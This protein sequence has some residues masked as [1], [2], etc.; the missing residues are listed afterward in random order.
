MCV[1]QYS[2]TDSELLKV[3]RRAA[4]HVHSLHYTFYYSISRLLI[5]FLLTSVKL[6]VK[7]LVNLLG[8][9]GSHDIQICSFISQ[10]AIRS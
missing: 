9:D 10:F 1:Y 7:T 5:A 4:V 3:E 6:V 8:P 2:E